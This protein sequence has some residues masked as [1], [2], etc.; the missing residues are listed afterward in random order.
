LLATHRGFDPGALEVARGIARR[1]RVPLV[2]G[3][4]TRLLVDLNRSPHN[5]AV[6]SPW[7]RGLPRSAR[8]DLVASFHAPHW[9]RVARA[10]DAAA[11]PVVHIAVHSFTP[12]LGEDV[13]DFEIALLYDPRR[14]RERRFVEGLRAGLAAR[15]PTLRIRR[16]APYR[17]TS[18]G[19]TTAMRRARPAADYL[20]I[21]VELNQAALSTAYARQGFVD[22]LAAVL[23]E[24]LEEGPAT[25]G[26]SKPGKT[27]RHTRVR[28]RSTSQKR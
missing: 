6:F 25:A 7:T 1:L 14:A 13:R 12:K 21:E 17:G 8:E 4:T 24:M 3:G 9:A 15:A 11:R 23:K 27:R 22:L 2:A 18:D 20:G 10:L 26:A 28:G 16:N 19:L 5:P